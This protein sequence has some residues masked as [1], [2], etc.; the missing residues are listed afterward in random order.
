MLTNPPCYCPFCQIATMLKPQHIIPLLMGALLISK[1][2][3]AHSAEPPHHTPHQSI[4]ILN[5]QMYNIG[6][7][8][9]QL[10]RFVAAEKK[11]AAEI[12]AYIDRGIAPNLLIERNETGQT[13]L[14]AAAFMGYPN[15]IKELLRSN[16]TLSAINATNQLGLSAW[17][18]ANI[19]YRQ[20]IWAC[21]PKVF[22]N[23][24]VLVPIFVSRPYY[25]QDDNPYHK[26]RDLLAAAGAK[27]DM[28]EAKQFWLNHCTDQTKTTRQR[29]TASQDLLATVLDEGEEVLNRFMAERRKK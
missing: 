14:I 1:T 10:E 11:A 6:E 2:Q 15:V 18:S 25:L 3:S 8:D 22:E 20:A 13:P 23:P 4:A 5:N 16:V 7:T 19:G 12:R 28:A 26:S 24:F 21:Q 27:A 17:V 29:V 9:P